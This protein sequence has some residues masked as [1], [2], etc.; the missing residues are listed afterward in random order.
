MFL[1]RLILALLRPHRGVN[2]PKTCETSLK[3][4]LKRSWKTGNKS[5]EK[6]LCS[7]SLL[8]AGFRSSSRTF[9]GSEMCFKGSWLTL[10]SA[11][12]WSGAAATTGSADLLTSALNGSFQRPRPE[13]APSGAPDLNTGDFMTEE[14]YKLMCFRMGGGSVAFL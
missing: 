3:K 7:C 9:W 13:G 10:Q 2:V 12:G 11:G 14:I 8:L 6:S 5:G 1:L 4:C